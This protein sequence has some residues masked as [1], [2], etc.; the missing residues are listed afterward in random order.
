M[1]S[2]RISGESGYSRSLAWRGRLKWRIMTRR[3]PSRRECKQRNSVRKDK[4]ADPLDLRLYLLFIQLDGCRLPCGVFLVHRSQPVA[5]LDARLPTKLFYAGDVEELSRSSI[6]FR[7]IDD[8]FAL[9]TDDF[10]HQLSKLPDSL[11]FSAA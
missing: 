3:T 6:G 9:K 4:A 2:I 1:R 8:K 5:K 11:I 10:P 7:C